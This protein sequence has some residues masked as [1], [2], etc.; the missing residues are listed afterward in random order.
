MTVEMTEQKEK[1]K[2]G[3]KT[4]KVKVSGKDGF[5]CVYFLFIEKDLPFPDFHHQ[6]SKLKK[7]ENRFRFGRESCHLKEM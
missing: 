4:D 6:T 3:L 7:H 5:M 1:R 2:S